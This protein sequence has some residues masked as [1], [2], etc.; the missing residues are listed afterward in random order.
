MLALAIP[1][2]GQFNTSGRGNRLE[3]AGLAQNSGNESA[4]LDGKLASGVTSDKMMGGYGGY[5]M[6]W[7]P[8]KIVLDTELSNT[9]A[10]GDAYEI[11]VPANAGSHMQEIANALGFGKLVHDNQSTTDYKYD[12]YSAQSGSSEN[13]TSKRFDGWISQ[14]WANYNFYDQNLD[15]WALCSM[16]WGRDEYGLSKEEVSKIVNDPRVTISDGGVSSENPEG[17]TCQPAGFVAPS[18]MEMKELSM[19]MSGD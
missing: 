1:L 2:A 10:V 9:G 15:P 17:T 7:N 16:Y 3:I 19:G 8:P 18:N 11:S 12:S 14:G 4:Q 6:W 13:Q 5:M